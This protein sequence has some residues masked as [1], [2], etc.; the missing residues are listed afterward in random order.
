MVEADVVIRP[1][2][3]NLHW[4][5]FSQAIDLIT[6]GEKATRKNLPKIRRAMNIFNRWFK[7]GR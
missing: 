6:E 1:D 2:V 5:N 4:S 7:K 3:K